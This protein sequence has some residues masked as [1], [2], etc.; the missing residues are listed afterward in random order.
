M[1]ELVFLASARNFW[2]RNPYLGSNWDRFRDF[3]FFGASKPF[4]SLGAFSYS[5]IWENGSKMLELVFLACARIFWSR[6]LYIGS[7]WG[8]FR[9]FWS[10]GAFSFSR[11]WKNGSKMLQLVFLASACNF[12]SRNPYLGSKWGRFR[13]FSFLKPRNLFLF[14]YINQYRKAFVIGKNE[15]TIE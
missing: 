6:M 15:V 12:W 7:R 1:L 5:Y 14:L 9:D 2:S 13:D 11:L 4:W 10:L 8:R 3:R